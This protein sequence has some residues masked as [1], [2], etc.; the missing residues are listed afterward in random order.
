VRQANETEAV[1]AA[2]AVG[3]REEAESRSGGWASGEG[4][5]EAK[6]GV[7]AAKRAR[8]EEA[9]S[10]LLVAELAAVEARVPSSAPT[11]SHS[12][13]YSS[14]T[15]AFCLPQAISQPCNGSLNVVPAECL[16]CFK[17]AAKP[18]FCVYGENNERIS[19]VC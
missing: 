9:Q 13:S 18:Y 3:N 1:F 15:W 5:A 16:L 2:A 4:A 14:E 17:I 7:V 11:F 19:S 10:D 12:F 8:V 6:A